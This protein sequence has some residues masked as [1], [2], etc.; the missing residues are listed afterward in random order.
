M[1]RVA[2]CAVSAICASGVNCAGVTASR[3][4]SLLVLFRY[5]SPKF[6]HVHKRNKTGILVQVCALDNW[7]RRWVVEISP[8]TD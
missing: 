3:N 2:N 5:S 4:R 7:A 6:L 8:L 1:P